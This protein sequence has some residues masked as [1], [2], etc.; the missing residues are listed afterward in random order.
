M[1]MHTLRKTKYDPDSKHFFEN[2]HREALL[3]W[4]EWIRQNMPRGPEGFCFED[5][6]GVAIRFDP[7][8]H[9]NQKFMLIE[10]KWWNVP[11]DRS[12][13]EALR[14]LD[15]L[16]RA[17]DPDGSLYQGVYIVEWHRQDE[18]ARINYLH[19]LNHDRLKEFFMFEL[20]FP[21]YF[22]G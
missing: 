9:I 22:G 20:R 7:K 6:D 16:L 18:F 2:D 1:T 21:S 3:P 4:R 10:F 8:T 17:G 13:V 15:G 14:L 11:L 12:Q 5:I 19:P